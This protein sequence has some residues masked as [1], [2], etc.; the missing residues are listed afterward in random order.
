[1]NESKH[2][3]IEKPSLDFS[4]KR[5]SG[6]LTAV[7]TTLTLV[8][9]GFLVTLARDNGGPITVFVLVGELSKVTGLIISFADEKRTISI[10]GLLAW[11]AIGLACVVN[12]VTLPLG[13]FVLLKTV[14]LLLT[15]NPP[16]ILIEVVSSKEAERFKRFPNC[17]LASLAMEAGVFRYLFEL[18]LMGLGGLEATTV[19]L[20]A[21]AVEKVVKV[22]GVVLNKLGGNGGEAG[23]FEPFMQAKDFV[24]AEVDVLL[25]SLVVNVGAGILIF[26][27]NSFL[28]E[29]VQLV[30]VAVTVVKADIVVL[31]Y[32]CVSSFLAFSSLDGLVSKGISLKFVD[33]ISNSG[34]NDLRAM[35]TLTLTGAFSSCELISVVFEVLLLCLILD[36]LETD[37]DFFITIL[38]NRATTAS[39]CNAAEIPQRVTVFFT[40]LNSGIVLVR[41]TLCKA[42]A[43][44]AAAAAAATIPNIFIILVFIYAFYLNH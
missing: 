22:N 19:L 13:T 33:N 32:S 10:L 15:L 26:A 25:P 44:A 6:D 12:V 14:L 2:Q 7:G 17:L 9:D 5:I 18:V 38:W 21:F 16:P 29:L 1:M 4:T 40:D 23:N 20:F 8:I 27:S 11:V 31:W 28:E 3:K 34:P 39:V 36:A 43:A 42:N 24:M 35:V 37:A 30:I 41:D